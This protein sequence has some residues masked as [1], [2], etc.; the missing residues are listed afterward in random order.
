MEE[1]QINGSTGYIQTSGN[2]QQ[3]TV[4]SSLIWFNNRVI[5]SVQGSLSKEE[6]INLARSLK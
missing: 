6:A 4:H 5:Y 1:V 3:N 2:T